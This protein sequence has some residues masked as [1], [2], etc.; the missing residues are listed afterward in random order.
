ME[1]ERCLRF[2]LSLSGTFVFL[3]EQEKKKSNKMMNKST[4]KNQ[5]LL[6]YPWD[7]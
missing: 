2:D 5:I 6:Y 4:H 3:M 7:K 1:M